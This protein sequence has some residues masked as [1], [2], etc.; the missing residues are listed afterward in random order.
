[1]H[2]GQLKL[3]MQRMFVV[4]IF[5]VVLGPFIW[6]GLISLQGAAEVN[7]AYALIV[8]RRLHLENYQT[9]LSNN[10]VLEGLHNS[11]MIS[12]LSV[13]ANLLISIPAGFALARVRT[14]L[15][16]LFLKIMMMFVFV[17]ILLLALPMRDMMDQW[18]L[19]D[20]YWMVALPM[21]A[22]VLTTL[23]FWQ[24]YA[25]FPEAMDDCATLMGMTPIYTFLRVYL[26]VSGKVVLY[27]AI[28][29]FVTTWNCAFMPMFMYWGSNG[30]MGVQE[31]LLQFAL[32]PSRIFLGMAAVIVVCLP[33][34]LLYIARYKLSG[35]IMRDTFADVFHNF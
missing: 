2:T 18:G 27:A 21:A 29:Q 17:P 13:T 22:M 12:L 16:N 26:P 25:R 9:V 8:P 3:F 7:S 10:G 11:L 6:C 23:T 35:D 19:S 1:M 28:M 31:S 30:K 20:S 5:A 4:L 32:N 33:C 24:F 34:W 15:N 14:R